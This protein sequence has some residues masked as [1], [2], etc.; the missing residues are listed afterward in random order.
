MDRSLA[1]GWPQAHT[2]EPPLTRARP[3]LG[4]P[5]QGHICPIENPGLLATLKLDDHVGSG[6]GE[7]CE[8]R[9]A[10]A[11]SP[12]ADGRSQGFVGHGRHHL[13]NQGYPR[14]HHRAGISEQ[15]DG[16]CEEDRAGSTRRGLSRGTTADG[17]TQPEDVWLLTGRRVVRG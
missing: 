12:P 15:L 17:D 16:S 8:R 9:Q 5:G 4:I 13:C 2:P 3:P 14:S 6:D 10:S 11:G 1:I 7:S